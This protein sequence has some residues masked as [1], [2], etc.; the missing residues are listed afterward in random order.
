MT[1]KAPF[2]FVPLSDKVFFPEW[3]K[4]ISHDIPF[5]DGESGII[6][7]KITAETPI[8][9]R[10]GHTE[11]QQRE[12]MDFARRVYDTILKKIE[13][14]LTEK[15]I[16]DKLDKL[17]TGNRKRSPDRSD[18]KKSL[19][20]EKLEN[21]LR[22]GNKHWINEIISCL[23]KDTNNYPYFLFSQ[24]N[25]NY[26]IP[27]TTIKG[28]LRNVLEILSF[29]KYKINQSYDFSA[30]KGIDFYDFLNQRDE[31]YS[32]D[33][34][35]SIFGTVSDE[36]L[37][38]RVQISNALC[39][40]SEKVESGDV[41]MFSMGTPKPS[42]YPIYLKQTDINSLGIVNKYVDYQNKPEEIKLNGWKRYIIHD[43][44][45]EKKINVYRS[46]DDLSKQAAIFKPIKN[47]DFYATIR[48]HNLKVEELGALVSAITF[49][50]HLDCSH[51]LGVAKSFG[52]GCVS[53]EIQKIV[54]N[55][56]CISDKNN[57]LN[58]IREYCGIF[59]SLMQ[60]EIGEKWSDSVYVKELIEMAKGTN[61][62]NLLEYMEFSEF[63]RAIDKQEFLE[64]FS[65][66]KNGKRT[67]YPVFSN[68]KTEISKEKLEN[69]KD[70]IISKNDNVLE[71]T[72][73]NFVESKEYIATYIGNKKV[74]I[75]D[76]NTEI[77]CVIPKGTN[78]P[79][80]KEKILIVVSQYK[81]D[82]YVN[83]VK[84]IKKAD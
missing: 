44:F 6:E 58:K 40:N 74:I 77:Q 81:K 54:L 61:N 47:A 35:E 41:I 27:A 31:K 43:H 16:N 30:T 60:D 45:R 9:V 24:I 79:N 8:F 37:K 52:Y 7:L 80:L 53:I 13:E 22:T 32:Y 38:G 75:E 64:L 70:E 50:N 84:Y 33:L 59:Q 57:I 73:K 14:T 72:N 62:P 26:F 18:A 25:G 39:V 2:N 55:G 20:I 34:A 78:E 76:T 21:E 56:D 12:A 36:S 15:E 29:G 11:E 3:A 4:Q 69:L 28:C 46:G 66:C 48:F 1:I 42:Y 82:G 71:L 51:S 10:N 19:I 68:K 49:H 65:T 63:K 67:N 83:Q 5:E 17:K 23:N